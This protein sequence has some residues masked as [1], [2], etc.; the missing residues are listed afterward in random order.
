MHKA[1]LLLVFSMVLDWGQA[2]TTLN[3]GVSSTHFLGIE[4]EAQLSPE[5][6]GFVGGGGIVVPLFSTIF[7]QGVA[8]AGLRYWPSAQPQG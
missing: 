8:S 7:A 5:L 4:L 2:Q 6:T 3:F 1:L